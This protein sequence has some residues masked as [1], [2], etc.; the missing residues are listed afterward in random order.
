MKCYKSHTS[1]DDGDRK[2]SFST[3]LYVLIRSMYKNGI[4]INTCNYKII[5]K[6]LIWFAFEGDGIGDKGGRCK[7]LGEATT[8]NI[9]RK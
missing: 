1:Y 5:I 6:L 2:L 7:G 9:Y 8:E 3:L 4:Y